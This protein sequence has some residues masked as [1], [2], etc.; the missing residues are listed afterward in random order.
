[1]GIAGYLNE[2]DWDGVIAECNKIIDKYAKNSNP[3]PYEAYMNRGYACCFIPS[4]DN[5]YQE[6]INDL[7][8]AITLASDDKQRFECHVKRAYAY[9]ISGRH[10]SAIADCQ[11]AIQ[12]IR[13]KTPNSAYRA[14]AYELLGNI[15]SALDNPLEA[16]EQYK[17]ALSVT[18]GCFG[19]PSLLDKYRETREQLN[20]KR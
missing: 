9:W 11:N 7:S 16:L 12:A 13:H 5:N 10:D 8:M 1:M 20:R 18:P 3:S 4:K 15:Y 19:N 14:F 2:Q 17:N 6:A